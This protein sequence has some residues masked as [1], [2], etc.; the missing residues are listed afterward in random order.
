MPRNSGNPS[1]SFDPTTL[2]VLVVDDSAPMREIIG[3]ILSSHGTTDI[4]MA[5]DGLE[6]LRL[7]RRGRFDFIICDLMMQGMDGFEFL[8]QLRKATPYPACETP[9]II[10]SSNGDLNSILQARD[11]G[12]NEYL[13]KPIS[14]KTLWHRV[15]SLM[16]RPGKLGKGN[17]YSCPPTSYSPAKEPV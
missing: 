5:S 11:A 8:R 10:L 13:V 16:N 9:T 4:A 6:A 15:S 12:M 7:V 2:Q 14:P 1:F 3:S 17:N